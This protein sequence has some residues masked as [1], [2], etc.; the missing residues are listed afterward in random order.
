[1][2]NKQAPFPLTPA[3]TYL[4]VGFFTCQKPRHHHIRGK[5]LAGGTPEKSP[6]PLGRCHRTTLAK[7]AH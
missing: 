6:A 3:S 7:A 5:T 1:M 2:R 4:S